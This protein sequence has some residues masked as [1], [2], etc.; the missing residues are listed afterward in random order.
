VSC[1]FATMAQCRETMMGM[2][3]WCQPNPYYF[4][5]PRRRPRVARA[6]APAGNPDLSAMTVRH[7]AATR[8]GAG[9]AAACLFAV[10]LA[11]SAAARANAAY[12]AV[13]RGFEI[14]Y[15]DCSFATFRA[16]L[17]EIRGLGG[18]CRPNARYAP[19]PP[20][21]RYPD[22]RQTRPPR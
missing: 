11:P 1:G 8:I 22:R 13:S 20:D 19:P 10:L 15:E 17:Q 6:A 21:R 12:C 3:G 18:S 2:G 14:S 5:G 9:M 16:C 7:G 4:V